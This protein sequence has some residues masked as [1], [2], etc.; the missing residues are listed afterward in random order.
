MP[1]MPSRLF[2]WVD[3]LRG[4]RGPADLGQHLRRAVLRQQVDQPRGLP[5]RR[6]LVAQPRREGVDQAALDA[7]VGQDELA[8]LRGLGRL[9]RQARR[10]RL[11][12]LAGELLPQEIA[13]ARCAGPGGRDVEAAVGRLQRRDGHPATGQQAAPRRH[14]I[15][16]AASSRR[17]GP[18]RS[19]GRM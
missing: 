16:G 10:H 13:P 4:P 1:A 17:P 7:G 9:A 18:A 11:D 19:P 6:D 2:R 8:L 15:P 14:R 12:R 3:R 5:L